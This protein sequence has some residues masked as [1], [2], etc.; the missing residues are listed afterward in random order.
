ML[1]LL[2]FAVVLRNHWEQP[3]FKAAAN[4]LRE[5]ENGSEWRTQLVA[6]RGEERAL[7][8]VGLFG[9][10]SCVACF[11][12]QLCVVEGDSYGGGNCG[13]KALISLGEAAFLLVR[14]HADDTH[15]LPA[16]RDRHAKIGGSAPAHLFHAEP[17]AVDFHVFIDEQRLTAA[18]NLRREPSAEGPRR[19]ILTEGVRKLQHHRRAVQQRDVGDRR[20]EEVAYLIADK[21]DKVVL[22]ELRGERLANAVDGHQLG[23]ALADLMLA[24]IDD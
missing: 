20:S 22:V 9:G 19:S 17:G 4:D 15:D 1:G 18:D 11:F 24:L 6:H 14:L 7:R 3:L 2:H 10:S 16:G 8:G 21:L 13:E 23:G 5:T 12:K